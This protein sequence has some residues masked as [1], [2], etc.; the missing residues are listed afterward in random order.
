MVAAVEQSADAVVISDTSGN[1]QYV[2]PAFSAMTGYSREEAI[3]QNPRILKSGRQSQEFYKGM[4]DTIASGRVWQGEIVNKRKNGIFY[5]EEMRITPVRDCYGEIVSYIAIKQDISERR[6]AEEAKRFLASIV[7]CSED[8]IITYSPS[9]NILTWNHGAE[10]L[11][12][13]LLKK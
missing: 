8:A 2:N 12:T 1:I 3:G 11:L 6:A 9:G 4:W 13:T 10:L 5:T 7:E